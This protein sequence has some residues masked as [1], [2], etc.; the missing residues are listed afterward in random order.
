MSNVFLILV[1]VSIVGI[2]S[3][4]LLSKV[5]QKKIKRRYYVLSVIVF[6]V[7]FGL[8]SDRE[9]AKPTTFATTASKP[10]TTP[11]VATT[12]PTTAPTVA[13][14]VAP[15]PTPTP[16]PPKNKPS[17]SK[18]EFDQ[19]QNGMT[20]AQVTEIIGGPGEI[21]SEVGEKG[22]EFYTV[23]YMYDGEGSLGANANLMFQGGKL[24]SKAQ[25]GLK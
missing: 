5:I 7:A 10:T 6:F 9:E 4:T 24:N 21:M 19:I 8:T 16:A 14:T 13:Q 12:A 15:T 2:C 3:P 23:M 22:S 18:A 1:L 20:Y 17:M 25:F 11:A